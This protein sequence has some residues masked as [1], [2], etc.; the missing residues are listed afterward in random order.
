MNN[1]GLNILKT[2]TRPAS[3]NVSNATVNLIISAKLK[4]FTRPAA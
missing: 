4:I 1:Q 2:L 3:P